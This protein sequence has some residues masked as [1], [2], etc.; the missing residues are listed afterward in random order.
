MNIKKYSFCLHKIIRSVCLSLITAWIFLVSVTMPIHAQTHQVNVTFPA[1]LQNW[2]R[3]K[4]TGLPGYITIDNEVSWCI[5][6]GKM[7]YVGANQEYT[8]PEIGYS[9]ELGKKLS[10]IAYFG[11]RI[12]PTYD[13]YVL[14]Q[15]LI[16][17]TIGTKAGNDYYFY[18]S[19]SYPSR[20]SQKAWQDQVMANVNSMETKPSFHA[21]TYS[22]NVGESITLTD[23]NGVLQH[24]SIAST[25]GLNVKKNGNQVII[26]A[27]QEAK[28]SSVISLVRSLDSSALGQLFAVKTDSS[29]SVSTVKIANPPSAFLNITVNKTGHLQITKQDTNKIKIPQTSFKISY[30]SDMSDPIGTYTTGIDGTVSILDLLPKTVYIQETQVPAPLLLNPTIQQIEI[31]PNETVSFIQTNQ[32]QK[33]TITLRKMDAE[34]GSDPQG[35]TTL[36]GAVYGLYAAQTI[37]NPFSNDTYYV[38]DQLVGQRTTRANGSMAAWTNLPLGNYYVKEISAPE[39]YQ[40]DTNTYPITL[41]FD[42]TKDHISVN[43]NVFEKIIQLRIKKIQKDTNLL[44][45]NTVFLHVKPDQTSEILTTDQNGECRLIGLSAGIHEIREMKAAAGYTRNLTLIKFEVLADG[46]IDMQTD[47]TNTGITYDDHQAT[48]IVSDEPTSFS[49]KI[50]KINQFAKL[51]D[52]A[53]FTLYSDKECTHQLSEQVSVNGVLHFRQLKDRTTYYFKETKAPEGYQIPLDKNG[54]VHVFELYVESIPVKN[55]FNVTIDGILYSIDQSDSNDAVHISG[56]PAN[57]VIE[58]S[59]INSNAV[60]LPHT[61]SQM[62]I[63]LMM[64]G[65]F[66]MASAFIK[67]KNV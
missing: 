47:F 48:I 62:M 37:V 6:P 67:Q 12:Q 9:E 15:N 5:E 19:D 22:L 31:K 17:E 40:L 60:Q 36:A 14:T 2:H 4:G 52:G 27:S 53:Q 58:I 42:P 54:Q 24:Y 23:T 65:S 55:V 51:L 26:T 3:L 18:V 21:N 20:E 57:R 44:I 7:A 29:Q 32:Y 33:G 64:S 41:S 16:W 49:L 35:D 59:V 10:Y 34:T 25:D 1:G 38:K 63:L 11:Y 30:N 56:T 43:L 8:F 46:T 45:P 28:D 66:L 39:G 61:G 13:N 50:T